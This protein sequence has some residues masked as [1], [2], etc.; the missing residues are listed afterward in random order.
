[1]KQAETEASNTV[2]TCA[3]AAVL[4]YLCMAFDRSRPRQLLTAISPAPF[5]IDAAWKVF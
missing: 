4:L 1:M 3:A 2:K 5:V